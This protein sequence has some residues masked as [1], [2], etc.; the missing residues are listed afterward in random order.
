M[1]SLKKKSIFM[2]TAIAAL[3]L[4]LTGCS[5]ASS[6]SHKL[7]DAAVRSQ[8]SAEITDVIANTDVRISDVA[9][10]EGYGNI[11]INKERFSD[12]RAI[13]WSE[14]KSHIGETV[15]VRGTVKA[16]TF[17]DGSKHQPTYIDLGAAYPDNS[18]V[19][20]VVWGEDREKFT[21]DPEDLYLNKTLL[22]TGE[23]YEYGGVAYI[24]VSSPE[25][26]TILTA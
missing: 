8:K 15:T 20:M 2:L 21:E 9:Y 10:V 25:Q 14:A 26:L 3:I 4:C 17:R 16:S 11:V 12:A 6:H 22:V 13:D 24:K 1:G 19:T 18:R 5:D 23:L 7:S